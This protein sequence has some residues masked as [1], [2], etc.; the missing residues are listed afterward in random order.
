MASEDPTTPT[1]PSSSRRRYPTSR[2]RQGPSTGSPHCSQPP[3]Q[4]RQQTFYREHSYDIA[5]DL[6]QIAVEL[7]DSVFSDAPTQ[8]V[9]AFKPVMQRLMDDLE[10]ATVGR[11]RSRGESPDQLAAAVALSPERLRKKHTPTAT[12]HRMLNRSRPQ[13]DQHTGARRRDHIASPQNYR[14]LLAALSFLQ[15]TTPLTQKVLA[16]QLGF[17]SSYVS[18]LLSGERT[19]SWRHVTKMTELCGHDPGLLRPLWN[20][21]FATSPPVGTDPVQY[22]RDHLHALRLAV[23]NPSDMDLLKAGQPELNSHHLQMSFTGPGVPSWETVRL[24]ARTLSCSSEDIQPLW[25]TAS[26]AHTSNGPSDSDTT[27]AAVV[28]VFD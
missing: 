26:A 18:R 23:G 11:G 22:L 14:R 17:T 2:S 27:S 25:R 8:Q 19:L 10:C 13:A 9:M 24:L 15:R 20:A 12:E 7:R 21:A 3:D 6:F 1:G 28:E 5:E 16:Q 4:V